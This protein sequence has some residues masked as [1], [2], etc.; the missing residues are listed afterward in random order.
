M[1]SGCELKGREG[2]EVTNRANGT[3][4]TKE[5][6]G[7]KGTGGQSDAVVGF[8]LGL[9][10]ESVENAKLALGAQDKG[11]GEMWSSTA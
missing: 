8:G 7:T 10:V 1:K 3:E 6:E 4:G 2:R 5:T 11:E 9:T